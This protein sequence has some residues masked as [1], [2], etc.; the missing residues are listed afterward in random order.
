MDDLDARL[1]AMIQRDFPLEPRPFAVLAERL[2]ASEPEIMAR[3]AALREGKII[4]GIRA[5]F[6]ARQ[7]GYVS[8]LAAATVDRERFDE[9]AANINI[10]PGV[11]HN[12][13]RDHEYNLWFTLIARDEP[14]LRAQLARI[15]A[16]PGVRDLQT[17]PAEKT[18]KLRVEFSA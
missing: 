2:G 8:A 13:E 3:L 18:Y 15:A 1:L 17:L 10:L 16:L 7:L 4:R 9:V 6:E 11:T 5:M 12:Y 14:T